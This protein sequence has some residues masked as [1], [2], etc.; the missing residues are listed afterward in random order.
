MFHKNVKKLVS[1]LF[2][3]GAVAYA[4][5]DTP[6]Q[7]ETPIVAPDDAGVSFA[8][9]SSIITATDTNINIRVS[10]KAPNDPYGAPDFY[11]HTMTASKVVTDTS[12]G[13]LPNLKQV[14]GLADTARI[15][16][17]KVND[18]VT[19]T[20]NVW[21]VRRGLQSTSPAVGR[22]FVRRG[23]RAPLPPDSIR[24]DTIV[25]PAAPSTPL[26]AIRSSLLTEVNKTSFNTLFPTKEYDIVQFGNTTYITIHNLK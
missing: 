17:K 18:T 19:L 3:M 15:S 24:V 1:L 2:V 9:L 11:R 26:T 13:N 22:L 7:A 14:N 4:C 21:S 5:T 6:T 10:W 20:S 23:D 25:V 16:L 12:T 8:L